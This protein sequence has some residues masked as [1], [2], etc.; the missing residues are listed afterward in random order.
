MRWNCQIA[1]SCQAKKGQVTPAFSI[2]NLQAG[3]GRPLHADT[4]EFHF[5]EFIDSVF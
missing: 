3:S 1:G 2:G 5:E 4:D